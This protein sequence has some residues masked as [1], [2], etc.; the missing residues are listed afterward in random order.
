[1]AIFDVRDSKRRLPSAKIPAGS[2]EQRL[3]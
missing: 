2:F 1:M 3:K